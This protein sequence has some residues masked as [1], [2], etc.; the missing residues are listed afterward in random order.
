MNFNKIAKNYTL[1]KLKL[2]ETGSLKLINYDGKEFSFGN[3]NSSL[4]AD[5][6]II[7]AKF[8]LNIIFRYHHH[9]GSRVSYC[10]WYPE[11]C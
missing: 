4:K 3:P 2:L 10:L 7:N 8:Y 1:S 5:I 11:S 9:N 6:K